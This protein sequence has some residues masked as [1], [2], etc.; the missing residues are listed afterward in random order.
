MK[1][2]PFIFIILTFFLSNIAL[3]AE[4]GSPVSIDAVNKLSANVTLGELTS[5]FG[6]ACQ[7]EG[8]VS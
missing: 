1:S 2:T 7:G 8:P 6:E 5:K 4:C 3:A